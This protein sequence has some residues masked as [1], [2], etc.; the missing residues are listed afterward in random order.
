MKFCLTDGWCQ[1]SK[2]QG[3]TEISPLLSAGAN[4]SSQ[5]IANQTK[6]VIMKCVPR[7]QKNPPTPMAFRFQFVVGVRSARDSSSVQ[8]EIYSKQ[9]AERVHP[10]ARLAYTKTV[11]A[12]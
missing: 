7:E 4:S 5:V 6:P 3:H 8:G 11:S 12:F 2:L 10:R 9:A 1:L